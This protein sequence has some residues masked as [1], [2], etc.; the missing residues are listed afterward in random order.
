[1][2]ESGSLISPVIIIRAT[3]DGHSMTDFS[4]KFAVGKY[5][6]HLMKSKVSTIHFLFYTDFFKVNKLII[7]LNIDRHRGDNMLVSCYLPLKA[8]DL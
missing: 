6:G 5:M 1:M 4:L 7:D 2:N 3:Q 8:N